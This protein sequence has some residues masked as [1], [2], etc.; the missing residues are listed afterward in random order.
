MFLKKIELQG[1]KSFA[2]KTELQFNRNLTAIVGPNGSGK[3]NIADAIRWATGEQS[4]KILR[5]K[6]AEEVIFA[7]SDKKSRLGMAEVNLHLDNSDGKIPIDYK[8]VVITRRVFRT[9]ESEYIIN[10]SK[11]RLIDIQLLL[12]KA[13]FGQHNY[14]IIGQG[15]IDSVLSQSATARK[16][17][18]DEATGVKAYQI[19]KEKSQHKYTRTQDN[20]SQSKAILHEIF[21]RLKYLTRQVNKLAK[22]KEVKEK[23]EGLQYDYYGFLV[24]KIKKEI[25]NTQDNLNEKEDNKDKLNKELNRIQEKLNHEESKN[26]YSQQFEEI[27]EKY[28]ELTNKKNKLVRDKIV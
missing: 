25:K 10:K 16:S 15:M 14:S 24:S 7:G 2:N 12:A 17:F 5:T 22:Q 26:S 8:E 9:G 21:P 18:F 3:S 1:F 20:L 6:K 27:Q 23:L 13:S 4:Q 28:N 19:K 11:V